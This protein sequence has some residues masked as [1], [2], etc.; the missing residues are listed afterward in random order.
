M[1][2]FSNFHNRILQLV[3]D[4]RFYKNL[5]IA[6]PAWIIVISRIILI[7]EEKLQSG[8]DLNDI[9]L[10]AIKQYQGKNQRDTF[11]LYTAY[12]ESF[13]LDKS[14]MPRCEYSFGDASLIEDGNILNILIAALCDAVVN[15]G[16]ATEGADVPVAL[17]D[18]TDLLD[19]TLAFLPGIS[20]M[21]SNYIPDLLSI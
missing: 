12:F 1:A 10:S 13:L 9:L 11:P 8:S 6:L 7:S 18:F 2:L 16:L 14:K 20:D 21:L 17:Y 4:L 15:P 19:F 5:D 3:S